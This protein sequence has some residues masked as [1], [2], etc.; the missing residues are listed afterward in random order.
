MW[1]VE[2]DLDAECF[3]IVCGNEYD[4]CECDL[5]EICLVCNLPYD[6]CECN[7]VDDDDTWGISCE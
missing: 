7:F 2:S 4:L 5:A 3:C 1:D 6:S